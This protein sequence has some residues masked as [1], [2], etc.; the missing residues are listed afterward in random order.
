MYILLS[1]SDATFAKLWFDVIQKNIPLSNV[2]P[3]LFSKS[4]YA[5]ESI[6]QNFTYNIFENIQPLL[7]QKLHHSS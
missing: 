4:S 3:S 2:C 1:K 6:F 7:R 5:I